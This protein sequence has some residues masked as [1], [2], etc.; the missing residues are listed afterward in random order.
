MESLLQPVKSYATF[1]G[2]T[3]RRDY[4][5][6]LLWQLAI[7]LTFFGVTIILGRH[8]MNQGSIAP[9]IPGGGASNFAYGATYL[10]FGIWLFFLIPNQAILV[11]RLHDMG[12]PGWWALLQI[13][14]LGGLALLVMTLMDSTAGQNDYGANPKGQNGHQVSNYEQRPPASLTRSGLGTKNADHLND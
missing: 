5:L 12:Q 8:L 7:Y 9:P 13:V 3:R 10:A 14:P 4:W 2:R 1:K 11:R 6:F